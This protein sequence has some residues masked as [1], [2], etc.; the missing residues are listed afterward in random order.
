[1]ATLYEMRTKWDGKY[2]TVREFLELAIN[3]TIFY[4][5]LLLGKKDSVFYDKLTIDDLKEKYIDKKGVIE[6]YEDD[7]GF[8]EDTGTITYYEVWFIIGE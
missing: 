5:K 4:D 1:M 2:L 3:N 7:Y 6:I 8:D